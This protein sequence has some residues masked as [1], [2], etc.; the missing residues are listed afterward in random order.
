MAYQAR[1]HRCLVEQHCCLILRNE[2]LRSLNFMQFNSEALYTRIPSRKHRT[3]S[4][5][6]RAGLERTILLIELLC[7]V[8]ITRMKKK[9]I[10][11]L[12]LG[13]GATKNAR[14]R[15]RNSGTSYLAFFC[16]GHG[17]RRCRYVP[18]IR[19]RGDPNLYQHWRRYA[20][21]SSVFM[22]LCYRMRHIPVHS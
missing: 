9:E 21:T 14:C 8:N 20:K 13:L 16:Y 3:S 5:T 6:A 15:L 18:S 12:C 10:L 1:T 19:S 2:A 17:G 11:H 7:C 22:T 4:M